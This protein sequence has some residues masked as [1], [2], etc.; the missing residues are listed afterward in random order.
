[1]LCTTDPAIAALKP[2]PRG[3]LRACEVWR[4]DP[5]DVLMVGDRADVD[6]A[7]AAAAGMP[8]VIIGRGEGAG[9]AQFGQLMLPSIERLRGVLDQGR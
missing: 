9:S 6:A 8:C 4:I 7:G 1:V 5:A 2:N 3:F